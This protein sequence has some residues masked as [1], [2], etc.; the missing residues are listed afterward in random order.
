MR[1]LVIEDDTTLRESLATR[2]ATEGFATEQAADGRE[3][4]Y[5]AMEY[6]IDL[7]IIDLGQPLHTPAVRPGPRVAC[8]RGRPPGGLM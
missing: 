3:G 4:L 6:P 8:S 1:I 5:Q 2:L 7:A